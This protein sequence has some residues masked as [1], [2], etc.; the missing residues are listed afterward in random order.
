MPFGL[1]R[2]K[3]TF[4][5][6]PKAIGKTKTPSTFHK[7]VVVLNGRNTFNTSGVYLPIKISLKRFKLSIS[8]T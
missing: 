4:G 3:S 7:I 2:F 6:Y 5:L 8:Y 1:D